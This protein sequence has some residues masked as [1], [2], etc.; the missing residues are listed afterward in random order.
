MGINSQESDHKMPRFDSLAT[1]HIF[2]VATE[3]GGS[4]YVTNCYNGPVC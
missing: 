1:S 2:S 4:R 3:M